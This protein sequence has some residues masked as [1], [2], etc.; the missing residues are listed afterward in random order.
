MTHH[1]VLVP[2]ELAIARVENRVEQGEHDV[3][4][5]KIRQRYERL[6]AHVADAVEHAH[7]TFAYDNTSAARPFRLIARL[8]HGRVVGTP[9][10]PSWAPAELRAL[11]TA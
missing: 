1:V 10:W 5:A 7:E 9:D 6:W 3:P 8:E 2:L 11:T 4:T